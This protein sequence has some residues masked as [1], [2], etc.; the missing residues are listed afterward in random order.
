MK[1]FF[2]QKIQI[3]VKDKKNLIM[4]TERNGK[5][6]DYIVSRRNVLFEVIKAISTL[7]LSS[8]W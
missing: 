5:F 3:K 1:K 8:F 7:Y 6:K 2:F 4:K